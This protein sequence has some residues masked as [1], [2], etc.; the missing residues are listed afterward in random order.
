MKNYVLPLLLFFFFSCQNEAPK[1]PPTAELEFIIIKNQELGYLVSI[2]GMYSVDQDGPETMCR[3]DGHPVFVV[4]YVTHEEGNKR[5]LWPDHQPDKYQGSPNGWVLYS[6][7]H[8]DGPFGME[9]RSYVKKVG[10][11]FL[12]L[13]FRMRE[14]D[15]EIE[16]RILKSFV[17]G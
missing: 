13:D 11:K 17:I 5:G 8:Y 9:T 7:T 16:K 2:P 4:N 6:Y 1:H 15:R 14:E 12:S 3:L 10:E